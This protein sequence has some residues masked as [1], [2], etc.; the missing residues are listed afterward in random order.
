MSDVES[1]LEQRGN[2]YGTFERN[3]KTT[4]EL[5][6]TIALALGKD[7]FDALTPVQ[8]E[9]LHMI[10]HKLSRIACGNPNYDDSWVDIAGYAKLVAES[11]QDSH[12]PSDVASKVFNLGE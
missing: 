8:R 5:F 10:C 12:Q 6:G 2:R 11:L 3:S 1:V 7:K 4:E 9:G